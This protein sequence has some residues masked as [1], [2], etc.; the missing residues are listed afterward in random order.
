MKRTSSIKRRKQLKSLLSNGVMMFVMLL[1]LLPFWYIV[2]NALKVKRYISIE[3][4]ILRPET[5]TLDNLA[6]AFKKM[7]YLTAF[8]NSL[9]T[10]LLSC[11]LFVVLGSMTGYAIATYKS[12]LTNGAYVF[13]ISLIAL[14]FQA[15]MVPLVSM[16]NDIG[17]SNS[18]LG[19]ALIYAAMF[20][21]FIVFLYTGFMRSLPK[22]LM[23]AAA[24]DGCSYVQTYTLVYMPLLKTITGIVLVLRGTYVWN[25]LQVP[26]IVIN[27]ASMQTLQQKLYVFSQS[28]I[29]NLDLVF[30]GALIVCLPLVVAFLLM[31]KSFIRAIMAGSIKG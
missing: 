15:A 12:R 29:G 26:L 8:Q 25:D 30:A 4:F 16:M 18:F 11:V 3:P 5:F 23:E 6:N 7:K 2:N 24:I 17:L 9:I 27:D 1:Y 13:F 20:M 21:P 31:Q 10:L 14:P 28:R 22:E 19:L